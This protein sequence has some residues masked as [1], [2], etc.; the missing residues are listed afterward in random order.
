MPW[1]DGAENAATEHRRKADGHE[2][3]DQNRNADGDG[4]FTEE[5]SEDASHE[6]KRNENRGER[7]G[8]RQDG[9][10][11]LARAS[12]GGFHRLFAALDMTHDVFEHDDR[13]IDYEADAQD[14]RHHRNVVEAE[15]KAVDHRQRAEN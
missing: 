13:V 9:E 14:Q 7:D 6:Q 4:E 8:H 3:R 12:K 11:D 5:A 1:F 10:P 15:A 2:A